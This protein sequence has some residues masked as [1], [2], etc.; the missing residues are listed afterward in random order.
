MWAAQGKVQNVHVEEATLLFF[1]HS[2]TQLCHSI[3]GSHRLECTL[4]CPKHLNNYIESTPE[5]LHVRLLKRCDLAGRNLPHSST[6]SST[7][8]TALLGPLQ[9]TLH[10]P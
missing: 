8:G 1:S 4:P 3:F 10:P 2:A 9:S 7:I 6:P 5:I